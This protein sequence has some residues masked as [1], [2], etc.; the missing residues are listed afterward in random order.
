VGHKEYFKH[1]VYSSMERGIL[2]LGYERKYLAICLYWRFLEECHQKE[3]Q[4]IDLNIQYLSRWYGTK[5]HKID[6]ACLS[7]S[8]NVTGISYE[9]NDDSIIIEIPN[10]KTMRGE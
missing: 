9:K 3:S 7:L 8:K 2:V 1:W 10:Y 6:E 5:K 4:R